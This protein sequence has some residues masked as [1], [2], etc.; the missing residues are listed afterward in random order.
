MKTS[1][2]DIFKIIK[3]LSSNEKRLF[4]IF[5]QQ[6]KDSIYIQLF[7][8]IDALEDYDEKKILQFFMQSEKTSA[9][10]HVKCYLQESIIAF[11]EYHHFDYSIE[12]QVQRQLQIT[13]VL[14]GKRLFTI[15]EKHLIKAEKMAIENH[16]DMYMLLILS[17]KQR[18]IHAKIDLA[19]IKEQT[20]NYLNEIKHLDNYRNIVEYINISMKV[21]EVAAVNLQNADEKRKTELMGILKNPFL[22]RQGMAVSL[23]SQYIYFRTLGYIHFLLK[24][25]EKS[26]SNLKKAIFYFD[27]IN[28]SILERLT[29]Y[30]NLILLLGSLNKEKEMMELKN[31]AEKL[32]QTV[33]NKQQ[34]I[35][36]YN[37][38]LKIINN[39]INHFLSV[40]NIETALSESDKILEKINKY[41]SAQGILVYY[42]NRI[43]I[44]FYMEDYRNALSCANKVL[45]FEK[46]GIRTDIVFSIK[47]LYLIINYEL[48][49]VELLA[50]LCKSYI[51][52]FK[53][54]PN[55]LG[56]VLIRFFGKDIS[57]NI[58]KQ[59]RI[60]GFLILKKELNPYKKESIFGQFDFI[61]WAESKIKNR[62]MLDILKEKSP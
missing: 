58:K 15:A 29:L 42:A 11:L 7:D 38:Y 13:E 5:S 9:F 31:D 23:T 12:I 6:N 60:P 1:S 22:K 52:E 49:N 35:F 14:Y 17:W 19:G 3:S 21:S 32:I 8:A 62:P 34:T 4:K 30:S 20:K 59:N 44:F 45:S 51:R 24:N 55:T 57:R 61:S 18:I 10:K 37:T 36:L 56:A 54:K 50:S 47:I 40:Y 48:G 53:N 43:S 26:Y 25:G 2:D 27:R 33:K 16:L 28:I 41:A 46:T 39:H